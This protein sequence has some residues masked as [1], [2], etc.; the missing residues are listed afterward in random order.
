MYFQNGK[1]NYPNRKW[2]RERETLYSQ[3]ILL[4]IHC[5]PTPRVEVRGGSMIAATE[6]N[7]QA[8]LCLWRGTVL[9]KWKNRRIIQ[10]VLRW[11]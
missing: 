4:P 6:D 9:K 5:L 7:K 8:L 11:Q 10:R 1:W 2:K 3:S